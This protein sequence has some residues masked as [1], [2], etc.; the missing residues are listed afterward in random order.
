LP[1]VSRR[2][3]VDPAGPAREKG[4]RIVEPTV[5]NLREALA[6]FEDVYSP[7]IV[8]HVNDYDVRVAHAKG[9]HVWHVLE[10]TDEFFLALEG[11][12]EVS[13][14]EADA[15]VRTLSTRARCSS[16]RKGPSTGRLRAGGGVMI[17]V[18][19]PTMTT[20]DRHRGEIPA[21]VVSTRGHG[22]G[23]EQS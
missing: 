8:G 23:R 9:E 16:C 18:A 15:G 3:D 6:L 11:S 13:L 7:R 21:H 17:L 5:V 20:G 4:P 12:F 19:T 2:P 1:V 22:M 14:R 10:V